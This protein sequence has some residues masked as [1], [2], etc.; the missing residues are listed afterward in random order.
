M[1]SATLPYSVV[2]ASTEKVEP[3]KFN[4]PFVALNQFAPNIPSFSD[5]KQKHEIHFQ[6]QNHTM[7]RSK[8]G[9]KTSYIIHTTLFY[10]LEGKYKTLLMK[11]EN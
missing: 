11:E 7:N 2:R 4:P 6:Y 9:A 5:K 8:D 10:F 3:V 1:A